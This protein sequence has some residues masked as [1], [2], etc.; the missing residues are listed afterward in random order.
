LQLLDVAAAGSGRTAAGS[1]RQQQPASLAMPPGVLKGGS[2]RE[3]QQV[4]IVAIYRILRLRIWLWHLVINVHFFPSATAASIHH[5][6]A[7]ADSGSASNLHLHRFDNA[8]SLDLTNNFSE[9]GYFFF[10]QGSRTPRVAEPGVCC[11]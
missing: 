10:R 1:R 6:G 7:A 11:C 9:R 8:C 4:Q 2:R 3:Q 5:V